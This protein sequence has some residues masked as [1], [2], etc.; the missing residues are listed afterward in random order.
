MYDGSVRIASPLGAM[1]SDSR[2]QASAPSGFN[3][4]GL[5]HRGTPFG[6]NGVFGNLSAD[7]IVDTSYHWLTCDGIEGR[8]F[9]E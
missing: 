4:K 2:A 5:W 1:N 3:Q 7:F 8:D 6:P 9:I